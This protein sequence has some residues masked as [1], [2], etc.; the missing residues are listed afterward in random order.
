MVVS[1]ILY[2]VVT[3]YGETAPLPLAIISLAAMVIAYG[4]I[5]AAFV[6]DWRKVRPIRMSCQQRAASM[7]EKRINKM[8]RERNK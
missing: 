2:G 6:Y 7:S 1:M 3:S 8:L 4:A 5:I